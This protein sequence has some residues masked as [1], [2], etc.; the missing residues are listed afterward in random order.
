MEG[1]IPELKKGLMGMLAY[2][3]PACGEEPG[4]ILPSSPTLAEAWLA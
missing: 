2:I 3:E 1:A 4:S